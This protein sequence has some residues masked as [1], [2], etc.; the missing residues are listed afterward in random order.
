[1][2]FKFIKGDIRDK[3]LML[4]KLEKTDMVYHLAADPD[5]RSSV[6][7]PLSS[8]DHNM[9]GTVGSQPPLP[10]VGVDDAGDSVDNRAYRARG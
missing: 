2:Q 5:V 8:Y 6:P 10:G 9:N 1:N 7:N 3:D 4:E